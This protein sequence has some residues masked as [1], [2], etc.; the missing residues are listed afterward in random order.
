V[1][2]SWTRL[3]AFYSLAVLDYKD[4]QRFLSSYILFE[5][6]WSNDNG[7]SED[8]IVDYYRVI[9]HLCA[10]GNVEKMY[11]P[12]LI[13]DGAGITRNQQLYELK[14]MNDIGLNL[15]GSSQEK[16]IL[17]LGCGRGRISLHIAKVTGA[18]VCGL[19]IDPSQ[20]DNARRFAKNLGLADRTNF[21]V[22]S[23]N[24]LP[25]PYPDEYF[26]GGHE[27]QAFTYTKNKVA[28]FQEIYRVLKPGAK[29]SYLDWVLLDNYDSNN[30]DHV[31]YVQKTMK[32]IGAVDTVHYGE[33]EAAMKQAGFDVLLSEDA[34]VNGHQGPLIN[35]ERRHYAWLRFLAKNLL[36]QRFRA[37][38]LRLRIYAEAFVA[39]DDLR[40]ATTSYQ[41]VC[42]KPL[43]AKM[44]GT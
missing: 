44:K 12:P 9:N 2:R 19:N 40:I 38:L 30:A 16:R 33:I 37:M 27:V 7:K 20:I 39:A 36:P 31:E 34:S 18:T 4:C 22:A 14:M 25:L 1:Y 26:D 5:G 10:L 11:I 32:F 28:L 29:F 24:D 13:E 6:D 3:H 42:Q 43:A 17:E 23:F 41:I 15:D 21:V 35:S 8:H